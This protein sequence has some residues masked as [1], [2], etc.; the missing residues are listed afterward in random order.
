MNIGATI[1]LKHGKEQS[2]LRRH[3]WIFSG[4]IHKAEGKT[5]DGDWVKIV[6][7]NDEV[8]G[9]GHF[10]KGS[11]AVRMLSY[12]DSVPPADFYREMIGKALGLRTSIGI[13]NP[14]TDSCRLIHGE[15]D[16]L[17]GL[18]IDLYKDT[19]VIQAHSHGMHA[20]RVEVAN[21]V[22]AVIPS[23]RAVYYKAQ[24]GIPQQNAEYLI[25]TSTMP[26]QIKEHN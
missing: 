23:L 16:G 24:T 22:K 5:G 21:A 3:P 12:G 17:P 11:I 26:A 14:Q 15:G 13:L 7:G 1:R 9:Y 25:G 6:S 8:L 20:D 2:L 4:A 19:A 18:I 10:Q